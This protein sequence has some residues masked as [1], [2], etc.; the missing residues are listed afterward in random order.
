MSEN[1][2]LNQRIIKQLDH[3]IF[4]GYTLM[5]ISLLSLAIYVWFI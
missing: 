1:N 3:E 4:Y 2:E 5:N